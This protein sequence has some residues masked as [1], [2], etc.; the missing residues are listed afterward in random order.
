MSIEKKLGLKFP[1][2]WSGAAIEPKFANMLIY[3]I[4]AN[5]PL[6]IVELGIGV[7]TIITIKTLEM[8]GIDYKIYSFDSDRETVLE[9]KNVLNAEGLLNEERQ[10]LIYS[11]LVDVKLGEAEYKYYDP[12]NFSFEFEKI[13]LLNIDGPV[14]ALCKNARYP[15]LPLLRNFLAKGSIVLLDDA[16]RDDERNIIELWKKENGDISR[17]WNIDTDRGATEIR[18]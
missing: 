6:N 17:V 8:L 3:K 2:N 13:D 7:S 16:K 12:N 11:P 1:I 15:A 18:F 4:I 14:G 9:M 10:K 5:R